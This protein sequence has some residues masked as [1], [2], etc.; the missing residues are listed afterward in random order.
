MK[1]P[2][3]IALWCLVAAAPVALI[4]GLSIPNKSIQ[5]ISTV[6]STDLKPFIEP[7]AVEYTKKNSQYDITVEAGGSDF[8]IEETA[9]GYANIGN[10]TKNPFSKV[11][12]QFKQEWIE[13]KM[14]T[15]TLGWEGICVVYIPPKGISDSA[16]SKLNTILDM[17]SN[18]IGNLY[19]TFSGYKD[20]LLTD[21]PTFSLFLNDKS[22][23][24]NDKALF[25]NQPIIP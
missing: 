17:N 9:Y 21:K 20:G 22:L 15:V 12:E 11:K 13:R 18:N 25:E 10:A 5:S 2:L 3:K 14:K 16:R 7:L 1:K 23:S 6:G 4:V 8:G 19:R 24:A